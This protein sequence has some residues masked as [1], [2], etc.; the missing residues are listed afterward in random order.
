MN[1]SSETDD[2]ISDKSEHSQPRDFKI[3][4]AAVVGKEE[5]PFETEKS[6]SLID[7]DNLGELSRATL[8]SGLYAM[9]RDPYTLF[10]YWEI[11]WPESF[12]DKPPANRLVH[13]RVLSER[14]VEESSTAVEPLMRSCFVPTAKAGTAYRLE[15]GFYSPPEIWNSV[16]TSA[17]V[18]TPPDDLQEPAF[19]TVASVPFHLSFQ[20]LIEMS[21]ALPT[22]GEKL[23][24][25][26]AAL[27]ERSDDPA[28]G[29]SLTDAELNLLRAITACV[30]ETEDKQRSRFRIAPDLFATREDAEAILGSGVTSHMGSSRS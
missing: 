23:V 13:L 30:L 21:A 22:D 1:S 12:G 15:I 26:I 14:G 6:R 11:D 18:T 8:E 24:R 7:F 20:R 28:S 16:E 19:F 3:S 27:Q 5:T 25:K 10:V 29:E 4:P 2:E 9:A 17:L